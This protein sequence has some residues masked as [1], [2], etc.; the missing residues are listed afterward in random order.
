MN[1]GH[2]RLGDSQRD[3]GDKQDIATLT[4]REIE[5]LAWLKQGKS[6]WEITQ[7]LNISESTVKFHINNSLSKLHASNRTH[8]VA[9][10]I[11]QHLI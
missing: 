4:E 2:S 6:T 10:A 7:I 1:S 5:V 8:A 11:E 9:I 3:T